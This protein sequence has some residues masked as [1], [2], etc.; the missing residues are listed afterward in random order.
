L[1]NVE[2]GEQE[3]IE[4]LDNTKDILETSIAQSDYL[5]EE[6]S[7]QRPLQIKWKL[8]HDIDLAVMKICCPRGYHSFVQELKTAAT[9]VNDA[10]I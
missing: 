7:N 5:S 9:V 10:I 2:L 3:N 6:S 8:A 1:L 4:N